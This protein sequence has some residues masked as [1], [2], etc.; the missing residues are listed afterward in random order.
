[1]GGKV[2]VSDENEERNRSATLKQ[3][4]PRLLRRPEQKQRDPE[5]EEMAGDESGGLIE[6]PPR[7]VT[8][9][10]RGRGGMGSVLRYPQRASTLFLLQLAS[11]P[12]E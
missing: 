12:N 10:M 6:K 3:R 1:V 7:R 11:T 9:P 5:D 2:A 4:R 8:Q